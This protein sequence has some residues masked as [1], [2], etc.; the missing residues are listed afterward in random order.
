MDGSGAPLFGDGYT[1]S[2]GKDEVIRE[3]EQGYIVSYGEM[4]YRCLDAVERLKADGVSIGL[5]NKPT[6]NVVDGAMMEKLSAKGF[7]MVVETQNL[8][9]GLGASFGTLLLERGYTG[10][11]ARMGTTKEG[12]GG[13][14]EQIPY[15][16]IGTDDIQAKVREMLG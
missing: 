16:G 8:K 15:Q 1:F 3:G 13:L 11:Y 10:K 4:L 14:A 12:H 6:L 5:I 2:P 9:T 7:V